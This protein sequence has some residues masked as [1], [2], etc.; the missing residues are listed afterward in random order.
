MQKQVPPTQKT[1]R[2]WKALKFSTQNFTKDPSSK[3]QHPKKVSLSHTETPYNIWTENSALESSISSVSWC[4]PLKHDTME[5]KVAVISRM[6]LRGFGQREQAEAAE[7]G[8]EKSKNAGV[9]RKRE[10]S[11][12]TRERDLLKRSTQLNNFVLNFCV[13]FLCVCSCCLGSSFDLKS[14][15]HNFSNDIDVWKAF[16]FAWLIAHNLVR[17][18]KN[19]S[20]F[21]LDGRRKLH[22]SF[23][24][25][26]ELTHKKSFM[27]QRFQH[28]CT[29]FSF[30]WSQSV[31]MLFSLL[32]IVNCSFSQVILNR[33]WCLTN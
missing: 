31:N 20:L 12:K 21:V 29:D 30:G 7:A 33:S 25:W 17:M 19:K 13:L 2:D 1:K 10:N 8:A 24:S 6:S 3:K 27:F 5:E 22:Q 18:F 23:Y 26:D 11:W 14:L 15:P 4:S 32:L 16:P 28:F 9:G